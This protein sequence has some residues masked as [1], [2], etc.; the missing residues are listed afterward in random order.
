MHTLD[1][2]HAIAAVA[3]ALVVVR[4]LQTLG[5]HYFPNSDAV[6]AAR[7]IFGGP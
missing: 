7:W 3:V 6:A 4:G 2:A 5:E 1:V